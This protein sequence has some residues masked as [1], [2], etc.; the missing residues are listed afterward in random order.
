MLYTT[1]PILQQFNQGLSRYVEWDAS[2]EGVQSNAGVQGEWLRQSKYCGST[3]TVFRSG[4]VELP[5]LYGPAVQHVCAPPGDQA[6]KKGRVWV[7]LQ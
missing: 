7:A 5:L 4:C 3:G 6:S 2:F 1:K